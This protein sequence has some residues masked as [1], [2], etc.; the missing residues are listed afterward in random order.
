ML[1]QLHFT[2][3][4]VP[5]YQAT[6]TYLS[7]FP[8]YLSLF[9]KIGSP[10]EK[11]LIIYLSGISTLLSFQPWTQ[12]S[13]LYLSNPALEQKAMEVDLVPNCILDSTI[14]RKALWVWTSN[15][16]HWYCTVLY[17]ICVTETLLV[18]SFMSP[19]PVDGSDRARTQMAD[20]TD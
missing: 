10:Q 19:R 5:W 20:F 3:K 14:N 13:H 1:G 7:T 15:V 6:E 11:W 4:L 9:K 2:P 18:F 17:C 8:L 16:T 12:H